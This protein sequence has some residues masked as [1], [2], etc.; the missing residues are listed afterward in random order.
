[1]AFNNPDIMLSSVI[2]IAATIIAVVNFNK[3]FFLKINKVG[4]TYNK[5]LHKIPCTLIIYENN[6]IILKKKKNI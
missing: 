4:S 3:N 6:Q 5:N 2:F 1:M